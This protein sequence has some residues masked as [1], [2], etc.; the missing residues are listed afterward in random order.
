M[1]KLINLF[2][3]QGDQEAKGALGARCEALRKALENHK[4][5]HEYYVGGGMGHDWS[6][7]QHLLYYRFLPTLWRR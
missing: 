4:I 7:W 5:K 3:G 1:T 6:T 2:V